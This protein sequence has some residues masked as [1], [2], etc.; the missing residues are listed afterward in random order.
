MWAA[1]EKLDNGHYRVIK[2]LGQGG[3][4]IVL[5]CH[6][7]LLQRDVAIKMLL[8]ELMSNPGTV[9]VFMQEARLAA[10]LEHPNIVTVFAVGKEEKKGKARHFIA[11]E[12]LSG[13]TLA[14]RIAQK[15]LAVEHSLSW[16]KQLANGLSFAHKKGVVHQDIKSDNVFITMEGDLKIGDFGLARLLATRVKGRTTHGMGTPAYMSPELCRGE[17]QD[18]RSDIYSMGVLFFEMATG[19]L[20]FKARGMIEMAMKHASAPVPSAR[21]VNPT[22]PEVLDKVIQKMMAKAPDDR[23]QSMQDVVGILD[24]LIFELRV[25]RLGLGPRLKNSAASF[26]TSQG[27]EA[28]S[29]A[30]GEFFQGNAKAPGPAAR[31]VLPPPTGQPSRAPSPSVPAAPVVPAAEKV[32]GPITFPTATFDGTAAPV[33]TSGP[34]TVPGARISEEF[35]LIADH[36]LRWSFKTN[37]PIGWKST[38]LLDRGQEIIYVTSADGCVYAIDGATGQQRWMYKTAGPILASAAQSGDRLFVASADGV[39]H[40]LSLDGNQLWQYRAPSG[41]VSP[42]SAEQDMIFAGT[43][44]GELFALDQATG[45]E[46]WSFRCD[47][48]FVSA[49]Q[50]RSNQVYIAGKDGILYAFNT[51]GAVKWKF[52]TKGPL[53]AGPALSVDAVYIGSQDGNFY[54]IDAES[55]RLSWQYSTD[56]P[57]LSRAVIV[58]TSVAFA[59]EDRWLYCVEKYD[60]RLKWKAAVRGRLLANLTASSDEIYACTRVGNLCAYSARTGKPTWAINCQKK[61]ESAPLITG[62]SIYIGTIEG[63]LLAYTHTPRLVEKSA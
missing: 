42:P 5:L 11:M 46:K 35:P 39:L 12:Y 62:T 38:C 25:A 16:M 56:K 2:E 27:G 13:G 3:M 58:F 57:I 54:A 33:T 52:S 50:C 40:G 32:S 9:E 55:G 59:G 4:G 8:P 6:D 28:K 15:D 41:F 19:E 10:Q 20:P 26:F 48:S 43:I 18:H 61:V 17:S 29:E 53:V 24:D 37:G 45:Q 49:P 1:G 36:E 7:E 30:L 60:G 21:K 14:G 22:V 63:D 51:S 47:G 44:G 31:D 34:V 23:H